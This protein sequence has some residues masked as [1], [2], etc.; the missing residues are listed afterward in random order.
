MNP[1]DLVNTDR[2]PLTKL[3]T[4]SGNRF[5]AELASQYCTD[6]LCHLP[7]FLKPSA[8]TVLQEE[9]RK[10]QEKAFF[11]RDTHTGYLEKGAD[12]ENGS[13]AKQPEQTD[14]GSV[15]YDLLPAESCLRALYQWESPAFKDADPY[16]NSGKQ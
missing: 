12:R 14:V 6:G 11:V 13:S 2:Y 8:L 5:V 1:A 3:D 9:A 4:A 7:Q 15:A 16:P 10:L